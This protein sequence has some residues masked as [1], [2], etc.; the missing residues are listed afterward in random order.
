MFAVITQERNGGELIQPVGVVDHQGVTRPL[1]K[2]DELGEDPFDAVH[3]GGDVGFGTY[4][5]YRGPLDGYRA[6]RVLGAVG[7]HRDNVGVTDEQIALSG[8]VK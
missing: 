4:V 5:D 1:A 3:V 6:V 8:A 2:G 7:V